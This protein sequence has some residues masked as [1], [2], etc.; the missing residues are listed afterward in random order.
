MKLLKNDD[1]N[2][3]SSSKDWFTEEIMQVNKG[4]LLK[5]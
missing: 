3:D 2:L 1:N 5:Y 4:L